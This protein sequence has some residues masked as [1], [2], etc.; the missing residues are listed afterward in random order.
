[1]LIA[2]L[3]GGYLITKRFSS[4]I[5]TYL[6]QKLLN[7]TRTHAKAAA[8]RKQIT[9]E[10]RKLLSEVALETG[11]DRALL[12]E[13][14]NGTSNLVGLPFLY[15]T[16]T[17]EVVKPNVAAVSHLYQKINT[18]IVAEFLEKLEET[19]YF[20]I[21]DLENQKDSLPIVYAFMKP[22]N[23]Q[24]ALFYALYGVDD[25][26][27]FIV[28]STVAPHSFGRKETLPRL[29]ETAQIISS[30]LNFDKIHQDLE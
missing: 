18:A 1:M 6:E 20:Y 15:T 4:L 26:I 27:G 8:Y 13:Y 21:D 5:T 28:I 19:G 7:S 25:T 2:T 3:Y 12:F 11:A 14:S 24:S 29:A 30:L 16:A 10:L 23:V 17:C 22:N 9:P